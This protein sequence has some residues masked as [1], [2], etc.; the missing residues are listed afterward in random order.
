MDFVHLHVHSHYSLLNGLTK[1]KPLVKAAKA[2]GFKALA[3]TDYGSMYGAIE[4]YQVCLDEGIKPIIGFEAYTM[5]GS[6]NDLE[7][8]NIHR[9]ILLAENFAGY[10]NLMRLSSRGHLEGFYKDKPCIDRELMREYSKGMIALSGPI[11]GEVPHLLKNNK[12]EE[13]K[14]V[15]LELQEIFG[16]G[17]F[18]LE[19]QDHPAISGQLDVNTKLIQIS[20]ELDIP[21]VVTRDVH[22]LDFSDAEAQDILRCISNGW[23]VDQ[24]DREDYRQVDRSLNSAE[25]IISR[26]RH[27]PEAIENTSKIAE[28][29]N[30]DIPLNNWHFAPVDI[31]EGKTYDEVLREEAYKAAPNFY[32]EVNKELT[33]R[34]DYELDIIKTKG[35]SPYFLCVGDYVGYAKRNGIVES[36]RGSAAGSLV[37]YVLGITTVDPMRFNLPFERFLNPFRPSPPDV[38]TDFADDRRGDMIKYVTEKYGSD[39]VAQIITFGTMAARAALRDVGRALGMSYNFCDQVAKLIPQGS[40]GF[41]MT[42]ERALV[43]EPD[44]KKLYESNED[45]KRLLDLARQVEGCNRHTSIHAAGVV[46][47]PTPLTDFTPVQRETGGD[48]LVTQYE[49]HAVET[50]GVLKNDFLGIRNLSILGNAMVIVEKTTGDKIDIYNLPLDDKATFEMLARGETMG[51][52]QLGGSGMTRWLK[53][54]KPTDINDIMAM[55]AL[56]RPGPMESIPEYIKRKYNPE[57]VTY[58]DPR[59]EKY[60]GASYGL[61]VYQDDV[62]LTA[63]HLAGYD[64]MEAD[65]FRKAMGK[66]IPEEMAKQKIKFYDGCLTIGK[67]KKETVDEIWHAI[68]P[69]AAYGFNKAHA[70][71]YGIVA[72]QTSYMKAHYPVQY[73][74]AV[75]QAESGDAEKVSAIVGEC[76]RLGIDVLPPDVNES[77]KSFAMVSKPGEKGRI[78]FGLSGIKNVG[79]HIC[80]VI[81]RE[82]KENGPYKSLE[83]LIDRVEDKDLNKKSIESLAQAGALDCFGIDRAVLMASSENILLYLRQGRDNKNTNQDSLFAG[84]SIDVDSKVSLKKSEPA[85]MEQKL[86]WE[87]NLLGIYVSSHPFVYY[88]KFLKNKIINLLE[89]ESF[90]RDAWVVVGGVID[91]MKKMIT[92]KGK[93]MMFATIQDITG[94]MELLIFPKT[95]EETKNSWVEGNVVCVVGKTPREEGDN[96]I[97]VEKVY[98]LN[99]KNISEVSNY[100]V[101]I[102]RSK[103]EIISTKFDKYLIVHISK[104]DLTENLDKIKSFLQENKGDY[105]VYFQI[106]TEKMKTNFTVDYSD[107]FED[108]L[109]KIVESIS[110]EVK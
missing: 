73:M 15:A 109:K 17:N 88:E 106:G 39:K 14:K 62:M 59:M 70:A 64:W 50:A 27:V 26:F 51:T 36:T 72:Y 76:R 4:F 31:P 38:D 100:L 84:T 44:L 30:L 82:R 103:D 6:R 23:R 58:M 56:Y 97:F 69:F 2:R 98:V 35:Y 5:S 45:V 52:F 83:D 46:I 3:L 94:R 34:L 55:V 10:Q 87:K 29:I 90:D 8:K 96:K 93:I 85:T 20:K 67:L 9:L 48:R 21:L 57:E 89:V 105:L 91:S 22:Y 65:K 74:T 54:L 107:E 101:T 60:L 75:L 108:E 19:M 79:E 110:L 12:I 7:E 95:Y 104:N 63:I 43:E 16:K 99:K 24:S 102:N 32:P 47:S 78:R 41:P 68:E 25:D 80:E 11:E 37:S 33:D 1:V 53:E 40:Q 61:L 66:K 13:A 49:M 92:K 81:Y 77:F 71:S 42:I 86:A 18:Y 28:R